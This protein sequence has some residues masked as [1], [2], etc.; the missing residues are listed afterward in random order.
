MRF[1][2]YDEQRGALKY[3][4]PRSTTEG[5]SCQYYGCTDGLGYTVDLKIADDYRRL[6]QVPRSTK[7]WGEL[8]NMRVSVERAFSRLKEFRKL[9]NSHVRGLPKIEI[10]CCLAV[11]VMQSM[12]L[13]KVKTE[14]VQEVRS[15]VKKV[16]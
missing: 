8:Y 2:S 12:A 7:Q 3:R 13:G 11:L 16:A 6:C 9:N 5:P 4:C 10:H 1:R 15:N 14:G